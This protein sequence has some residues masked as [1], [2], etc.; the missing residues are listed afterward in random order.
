[1]NSI[2]FFFIAL[3]ITIAVSIKGQDNVT[4]HTD[5]PYY[6]SGEVIWYKL[7]LPEAFSNVEAT[8]KTVSY[9]HLTLPT[10]A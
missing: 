1:M 7:Y 2:R 10:K 4:V 5:K 9:T 6:V 8:F 3:F